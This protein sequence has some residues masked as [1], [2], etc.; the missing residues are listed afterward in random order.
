MAMSGQRYGVQ[1]TEVF[2]DGLDALLLEIEMEL[3]V[4][5]FSCDWNGALPSMALTVGCP[6]ISL[7]GDVVTARAAGR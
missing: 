5:D 6:K 2:D 4:A 7:G 1:D 3:E